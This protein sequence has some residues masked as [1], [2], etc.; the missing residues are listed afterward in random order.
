MSRLESTASAPPEQQAFFT[1]EVIDDKLGR[2]E[3]ALKTLMAKQDF[4]H[5]SKSGGEQS[6]PPETMVGGQIARNSDRKRC[7]ETY[8][9]MQL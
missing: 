9:R 5:R 1:R 7:I 8:S 4:K 2:T 3:S 6:S